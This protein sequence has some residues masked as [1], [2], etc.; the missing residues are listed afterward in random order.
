M[1]DTSKRPH[2][3]YLV[4]EDWYFCSHRIG[5][6]KA[7]LAEG[8]RVTVATQISEHQQTIR[9]AGIEIVPIRLRRGSRNP[10][11]ELAFLFG[12]IRIYRRI[13]PDIAHH[14]A[15]KPVLY[16]SIAAWFASVPKVVNALTG[17]GYVFISGS[18]QA[19]LLR[20][21]I[22]TALRVLLNRSGSRLIMQ[23]GDD[24][25]TLRAMGIVRSVPVSL[26]RGSG[27]NTSAFP[28]LP[29]P[30]QRPLKAALVARMLWDKGVGEL[31][32]ASRLLRQ[33][34]CELS[35][36]LIGPPDPQNP[37]N[38]PE[39]QLCAWTDEGVV[40]WR[41]PCSDVV[42]VWRE[43]AIAVL[44]SYREGLPKALLEA[45]S[46]GRPLVATDA[47]GCREICRDGETGLLV[48]APDGKPNPERLADALQRLVQDDDLRARLGAGARALVERELSEEIVTRATL[49]AY[50]QT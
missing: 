50:R 48:P 3:L 20:L 18:L 25:K 6:A 43:A 41:G 9:D 38:I 22:G 10:F 28:V 42:G 29:E 1:S 7:A 2:I 34:G 23:N 16:G 12:L 32:A 21:G 24:L 45:A 11:R 35:I 19:R 4:T 47:P 39:D 5:I 46:C 49:D 44:P 40:E 33:R 27:V 14:A 26:I 8:Y 31:V 15:I 17:L 30:A 36:V 37:A 13:R